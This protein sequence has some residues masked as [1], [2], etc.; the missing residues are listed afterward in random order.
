V[1][2]FRVHSYEVDPWQRLTPRSLCALLQEA[3]GQDA[4]TFG[5]SMSRLV[6]GGLAW[7]LQRLKVDVAAYPSL[8]ARLAVATWARHFGRVVAEREF[9]VRDEAGRLLAA[10]TSRWVVMDM[11]ARRVVRLPDFIRELPVHRE[12]ALDME[13]RELPLP[14]PTALERR[15]EVRRSDLDVARHVNNTR[16]VEWALEA[17]PDEV[18][19]THEA[20]AFE[21]VFR[22]ESVF[23]DR[24]VS[25]SRE[26]PA[27]GARL[28]AHVLRTAEGGEGPLAQAVSCW[29]PR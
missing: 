15:F 13:G 5:V 1:A 11:A 28:F 3:A 22:R 26:L 6:E 21:I 10:A 14:E 19:E 4:D 7:V 25:G 23:G 27:D 20:R 2:P 18:Y 24:I 29:K 12:Q 17:V 9:E 8:G 16:Y